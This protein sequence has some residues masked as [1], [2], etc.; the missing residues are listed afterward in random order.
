MERLVLAN[1]GSQ[2]FFTLLSKVV[3]FSE[4]VLGVDVLTRLHLHEGTENNVYGVGIK[5]GENPLRRPD[6][7]NADGT[8][9]WAGGDVL[10]KA[11]TKAAR[12]VFL[13]WCSF[14][15]MMTSEKLRPPQVVFEVLPLKSPSSEYSVGASDE[16]MTVIFLLCLGFA[17]GA[18]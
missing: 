4:R 14:H 6:F 3:R 15:A 10:G 17:I 16:E 11:L 8:P 5:A 12:V 13:S 1:L 9:N 2:S 18:S 7:W